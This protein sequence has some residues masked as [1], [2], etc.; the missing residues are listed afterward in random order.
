MKKEEFEKLLEREFTY[1]VNKDNEKVLREF[2]E[3]CKRNFWVRK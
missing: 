1:I 3:N 2:I